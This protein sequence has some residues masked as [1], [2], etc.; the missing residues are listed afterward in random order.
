MKY[1]HVRKKMKENLKRLPETWQ[2]KFKRMY[3]RVLD[4]GSIDMSNTIDEVIDMMPDNKVKWANTQINNSI[5]SWK[6]KLFNKLI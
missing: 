5:K 4:N 6:L 2:L 1:I 3:S